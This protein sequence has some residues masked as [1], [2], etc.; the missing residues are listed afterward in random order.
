MKCALLALLVAAPALAWE[1]AT[2]AAVQARIG[3][4]EQAWQGKTPEQVA[5]DKVWR[6]RQSRP[7]WAGK[8]A[9]KMELG[10]VTYYFAVGK[11]SLPAAAGA[12]T[13][14]TAPAGRALDW[15]FDENTATLYTLVVDAR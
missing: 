4:L 5:Q 9:W 13:G 8:S 1:P 15:W 12:A 14:T 6:A 3:E 11:A 2:P 10:T 7:A